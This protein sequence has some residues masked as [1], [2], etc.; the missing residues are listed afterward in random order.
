[1]LEDINNYNMLYAITEICTAEPT[2]HQQCG[3]Q[4]GMMIRTGDDANVCSF[5]VT[6]TP[7]LGVFS[8]SCEKII[9]LSA[10]EGLEIW[11]QLDTVCNI[12]KYQFVPFLSTLKEVQ[13]VKMLAK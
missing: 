13:K 1:M 3:F 11:L 5:D 8:S 12:L 10:M 2:T 6:F 4:N 7:L 9:L